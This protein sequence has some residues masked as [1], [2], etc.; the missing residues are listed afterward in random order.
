MVGVGVAGN[1]GVRVGVAVI[2]GVIVGVFVGVGVGPAPQSTVASWLLC[3][4]GLPPVSETRLLVKVTALVPLAAHMN[5]IVA[6]SPSEQAG[7]GA[8]WVAA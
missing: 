6:I 1:V 7:R 3:G 2:V 4:I 5:S 8:N